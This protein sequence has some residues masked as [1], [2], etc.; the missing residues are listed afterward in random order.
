MHDYVIRGATIVDGTGAAPF[1]GDLAI[2]AGRISAVGRVE[3]RARHTIDAQGAFIAPGWVDV[4]THYDGQVSWDDRIDPSFG[5]GVTTIVMGNCG[6]GFAPCP[7][8]GEQQL[9][10]LM[11]GV[12]DIPGTALYEGIEWGRWESFPEYIDYLGT[13]EY[14]LDVGTQ[15]PH[16]ALRYYVMGERAL[17]H[18][19]AD[20]QDLERMVRPGRGGTAGGCAGLLHFAHHRSSIRCR[21]TD[22]G[23][24][25]RRGGTAGHRRGHEEGRQRRFSGGARGRR[26]RHRRPGE[27]DHR[28]GGDSA[29]R[30]CT[31]V[32]PSL[33]V[34]PGPER[35]STG[36]VA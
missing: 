12:E 2:E 9:I 32:R 3:G 6:V 17:R 31:D 10:E 30:D 16:S 11:E 27:V 29:R 19:D 23:N 13:R 36:A 14:T 8:G 21:R 20:A 26:R 22:P 35:Q 1:Q 18:E 25:R 4:H 5:Q 34:Y 24:L 15:V 33:Y 7:P 28:T